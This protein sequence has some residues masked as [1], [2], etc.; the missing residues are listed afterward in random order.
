MSSSPPTDRS[1]T[2]K[3]RF[4][5]SGWSLRT[6]LSAALVVLVAIVC[7]VIG[8]ATTVAVYQFQVSR[9]DN[10][11]SEAADRTER[12]G[13]SSPDLHH[14]DHGPPLA[15]APGM[16]PGT[17]TSRLSD[18]QVR[19]AT[20]LDRSIAGQALPATLYP[21]LTGLP[22]DKRP[23][24]RGL[25]D[26]GDYRLVASRA[27]DGDII[28]TGLPMTDVHATQKPLAVLENGVGPVPKLVPPL[29]RR[30]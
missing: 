17:V 21:V 29:I 27:S 20:V 7:A 2:G 18:G 11:L 14:D 8:V 28:I 3:P 1:R 26:Y 19:E 22:V 9:L 30:P 6:R 12:F 23:Y 13:D 24:T 5:I 10:Q 16:G 4:G 15:G 25:G